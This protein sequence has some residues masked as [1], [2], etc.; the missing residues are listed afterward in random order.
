MI[1]DNF[2]TLKETDMYSLAMFVLFK[3]RDIKEYSIVSELP[4]VLDKTNMLNFCTY[5]GGRT[6]KV[7]TVSELYNIINVIL[8]YQ[9]VNID[10]IPYDEAVEKIGFKSSELRNVK[11]IYNKI[12]Q[13]LKQYN[14]GRGKNAD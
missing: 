4:Y 12:G 13:V 5:F 11:I 1:K 7:P 3:L 10:N 8:L 6:I 14:F 2:I 9:Y